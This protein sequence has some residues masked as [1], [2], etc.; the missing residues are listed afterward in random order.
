MAR[1]SEF[2]EEAKD[3]GFVRE[4]LDTQLVAGALLDRL[5]NQVQFA[6]WIK[7]VYGTDLAT[8]HK[9]KKRWCQSNL[10]LFLSGMVP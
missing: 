2:L 9:Y 3:K 6:P 1:F 8:D 10:D 7:R 5:M 4:G